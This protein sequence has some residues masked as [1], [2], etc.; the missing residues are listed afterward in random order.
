MKLCLVN[1][2]V[3]SKEAVLSQ[4]KVDESHLDGG[5]PGSII[6]EVDVGSISGT[7]RLWSIVA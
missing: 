3:F 7:Y 1:L 4:R 6:S 2:L 5:R